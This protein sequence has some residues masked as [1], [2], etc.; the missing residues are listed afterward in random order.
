MKIKLNKS[1]INRAIAKAFQKTSIEL[2]NASQ[3]AIESKIYPWDTATLRKNGSVV[4][5]PRDIVDT[6]ELRDSLELDIGKRRT[7]LTWD[8]DYA[9]QVHEGYARRDGSEAPA[10]PW[11]VVAIESIDLAEVFAVA[12]AEAL[13]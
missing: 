12:M 4:T 9:I 5:S 3:D 8:V 10:R 13:K 1:K 11:T 7:N 6:G 2:A